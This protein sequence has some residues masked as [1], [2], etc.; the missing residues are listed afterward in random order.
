MKVG[1][2]S[3]RVLGLYILL[4]TAWILLPYNFLKYSFTDYESYQTFFTVRIL[5]LATTGILIFLLVRY[6]EKRLVQKLNEANENLNIF[7]YKTHHDIRGPV[8]TIMGLSE[9]AKNTF[10]NPVSLECMEKTIEVSR[11]MDILISRLSHLGPV[12]E[13]K[14]IP[15]PIDCHKLVN[16][17]LNQINAL[18]QPGPVEVK[19]QLEPGATFYGDYQLIQTVFYCLLENAFVFQKPAGQDPRIRV[20]LSCDEWS[21][22]FTIS[23]NGIG[24]DDRTLEKAFNMFYRGSIQSIGSG[25]GLY[26]VKKTL[27][28]MNGTIEI[29]SQ[30]SK[31]TTV[32]IMIPNRH[33][34]GIP[35]TSKSPAEAK[36]ILGRAAM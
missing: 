34:S 4:A 31:G 10:P 36:K 25:L 3:Y 1:T 22:R 18:L 20:K 24:M 12:D 13:R 33:P 6:L 8:K 15:A 21:G 30:S 19:V 28:K 17:S 11:K 2:I 29:E 7:L 5:Y 14:R 26:L 9:M 23:D 35:G 27:E 16:D 32:S